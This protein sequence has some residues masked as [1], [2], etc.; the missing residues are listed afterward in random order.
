M[1]LFLVKCIHLR[2]QML[3]A[4]A[5]RVRRHVNCMYLDIPVCYHIFVTLDVKPFMNVTIYLPLSKNVNMKE[6][7]QMKLSVCMQENVCEAWIKCQ[8]TWLKSPTYL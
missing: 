3:G 5:H 6:R 1:H 7:C 8:E 4:Q 2:E